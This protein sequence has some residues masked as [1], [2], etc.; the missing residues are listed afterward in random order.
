M[1]RLHIEIEGIVQG[2]G[3]RPFVFQLARRLGVSGWV[4]NDSRGV[5]IAA[6]AEADSLEA[7]CAALRVEHPPLACISRFETAEVPPTGERSFAI[8]ESEILACRSAQIAPDAATCPDCL[9]EL[10]DPTDRR[11]SYPFIN[12]TNCGPRYTIVTGVPY[13]RPLTTMASFAMCPECRAEYEDP[14]S[15]RFHAQPNACPVCG[16]RLELRDGEGRPLPGEPLAETVRL[17]KEGRIVAIKGLGGYHLAVDAAN[18]DAVA[19]LRRRKVR[20]EKPFA[21]MAFD[22]SQVSRF[23]ETNEAER[24]LLTGSERPI[25]LLR[26]RAGGSISDLVAP[27]N[28]Y[29]GVMLPYTP[30]HHLLLKD[31]FLALVMTSANLSDEPIAYRDEEAA[32]QLAGIADACLSHDRE[33][34]IRTDDSIARVM[35]GRPLLLRRSRG[36][37]PRGIF[38]PAPQPQVLAVGAELKSTVCLTQDDRAFLSHH[39][40]DLKNPSVYSSFSGAV[41]HLNGLLGIRPEVVA[42]DLHPDYLSTRYAETLTGVRRVAVQH[43]HAHLASCLAEN[44]VTDETIGVI[45]DG[46]GYGSD[47]HIW[48]GEFLIGGFEGFRRAAHLRYAA[49]PGGDAVTRE[50]F[51]MALSYLIQA[52]GDDLPPL[53]VVA[54]RTA[55]ELALF[56]R[57][58]ARG[59]NSPLTSSCGRLFDAVSALVGLRQRVSYEGQAALELEMAIGEEHEERRYPFHLDGE[60]LPLQLDTAA[61]IRAIVADLLRGES[62]AV[63]SA[64]FHNTLAEAVSA[65]CRRLRT[66]FGAPDRVALSGG[67]F[68][69]VSLT[70][71]TVHLLDAAGFTVLTHSLVPPND[72]GL[73]LG[74]AAIAGRL[75]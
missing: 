69:N 33:I 19:E 30:L 64:R 27:G 31:N 32:G 53:P 49:M 56:R 6:E 5:K 24:R 66:E 34:F 57:M 67:V 20:D 38:L 59:I 14:G 72:G 68:Q 40:G 9:R 75:A 63:V 41:D 54:E 29:F 55:Q 58:I 43:H 48:G 22:L 18:S 73:A 2:V 25:V 37:V 3:F 16:P 17:L 1:Q 21:L 44:G 51:R 23:A 46:T 8:R 36:F 28:H 35:A 60:T 71:R 52:F 45:F 62:V 26:R 61:L 65:V 13:D 11:Y 15:R 4:L 39:I 10:D 70:E 47:G 74:Q 7:F 50:P 12:C 42:H